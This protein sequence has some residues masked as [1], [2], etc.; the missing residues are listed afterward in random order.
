MRTNLLKTDM[1]ALAGIAFGALLGGVATAA[2]AADGDDRHPRDVEVSADC[3]V[4]GT[5][6]RIVVT[7]QSESRVIVAPNVRIGVGSSCADGREIHV[8][9]RGH[10][11][12]HRVHVYRLDG[13][14]DE[15]AQERM[16]RVR[17]RMERTQERIERARDRADRARERAEMA[18]LRA[19]EARERMDRHDLRDDRAALDEARERLVDL[20]ARLA[21]DLEAEIREELTREMRRLRQELNRALT[22][23]RGTGNN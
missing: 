14:M 21:D 12:D 7:G 6:P 5:T 18:R 19:A 15:A 9:V 4:E 13:E 10:D 20:E 23:N 11:T 1:K 22:A 3:A 16:E 2:L 17:E 8:A